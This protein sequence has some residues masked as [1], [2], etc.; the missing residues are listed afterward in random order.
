VA[1][2]VRLERLD[3]RWL[4][5][6][7]GLVADPE[8]LRFTRIP[9]PPPDGFVRSW[10]D[11]YE[12]GRRDGSREG[13]AAFDRDDRF[14]GLGLAP[15]IDRE[16]GELE[17]G[18]IVAEEARGR[19]IAT[20]VLRLLT[21]WAFDELGAQ[22]VYLI[23]DVENP[24]SARV[25]ERCGYRLEGVMRSIHLKQARRVDAGLWSRLPS[26]PSPAGLGA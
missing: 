20:E 3:E 12:A 15:E 7:A 10:I 2:Q 19:G 9:E 18:Y 26:D 25:A 13:F 4:D 24:A 17:L 22:R 1:C 21:R 6:V 16:A 14:V 11:M 8:V 5:E 23:I